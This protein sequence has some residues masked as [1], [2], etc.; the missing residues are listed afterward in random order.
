MRHAVLYLLV[1][2]SSSIYSQQ[3]SVTGSGA[4]FAKQSIAIKGNNTFSEF[5][6]GSATADGLGKFTLSFDSK[7]KGAAILQV[8]NV[9]KIVL[10]INN[11]NI[12]ILWTD[13]SDFKTLY[14]DSPENKSFADGME[15]YQSAVSKQLGLEY[16]ETL[17]KNEPVKSH[18]FKTEL[19]TVKLQYSRFITRVS[20]KMYAKKYLQWRGFISDMPHTAQKYTDR[21]F[22]HET[23]FNS[24]DFGDNDLLSSGLLKDIIEG[25]TQLC[26][27]L[28]KNECSKHLTAGI[29]HVMNNLTNK[30]E[31]MTAVSDM[32]FKFLEQRN[33]IEPA[34]FLATYMLNN[35][36]CIID[37]KQIDRYEQYRKMSIG[38]LAPNINLSE[39]SNLLKLDNDYKLVIFGAS[40]CPMCQEEYPLLIEKYKELKD[41]YNMEIVYISLDKDQKAYSDFF[42]DSPFVTVY[43]GKGWETK[44][45]KEYHVFATPT[46]FLLDKNLKII[47]KPENLAQAEAWLS[48]DNSSK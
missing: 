26:E 39:K 11:E 35:E 30:Q 7:Y 19:D 47:Q 37:E 29:S 36:K 10:L 6:L 44:T 20:D 43:G 31:V 45:A 25:Y 24:I 46:L 3:K 38:N 15:I 40:T 4:A 22:A 9:N 16:L 2:V 18:F 14:I 21:F 28:G 34:A 13:K 41:N 42:K 8:D 23:Y 17:Y 1:L 5:V 12:N 48:T 33:Q 32:W 27:S